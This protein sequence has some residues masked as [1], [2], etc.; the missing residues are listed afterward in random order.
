MAKWKI[1]G[2]NFDHMHMGDQLRNAAETPN[3]EVVGVADHQPGRMEP[4]IDRLGIPRERCFEDHRQCL[5]Q[6]RPD[7]VILCP[8]TA[9]HGEW[10]KRV[11]PFNAHVMVEKPFAASLAEADDMIQAMRQTGKTLAINWP[12][13][14]YRP[15]R[16][17][18]RLIDEDRIGPV[19]Q[20]HYYDGNRGPLYHTMDKI[21]VSEAEFHQ[22]KRDSWFYSADAGG[23]AMLDY[24]GYGTTL[25]TWF[26]GGRKPI[27]VTS[28]NDQP[29]GL[30]V[31]EHSIT[32]ARYDTGLSKFQ[33][34]WGTF[35]DPWT[36]QPQPKCGF[37][38]V[39]REGTVSCYDFEPH[40]RLQTMEKPEGKDVPVDALEPPYQGPIQYMLDCLEH[41]RPIEGPLSPEVSRIGQQIVD[42][43][44]HSAREQRTL[45]L[46]E[47]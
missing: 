23:G 19:Q 33:T 35:T 5:E 28:V 21:E 27:D 10:L 14:W 16:T 40:V 41:D 13:T 12:M 22:A 24:L 37:V 29:N 3:A 26:N 1:A 42:T 15:H 8:S 46:I 18:K 25:G 47:A 2:I 44:W 31:D 30:E 9:T 7:L 20:V 38:I 34:R 32:V 11:A 17:A 6:T 39:G 43:A 45:P 4:V 36:H